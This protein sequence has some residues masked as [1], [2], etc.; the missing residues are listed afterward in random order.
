M[1]AAREGPTR[2]AAAVHVQ[3]PMLGCQVVFARSRRGGL[4]G[5]RVPIDEGREESDIPDEDH[6]LRNGPSKEP[7]GNTNEK[8]HRP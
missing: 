5:D 1:P 3:C 2:R 4:G 7:Q 6:P 8:V